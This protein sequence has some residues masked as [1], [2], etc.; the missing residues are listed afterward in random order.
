MIKGIIVFLS[1]WA[2]IFFGIDLF[3]KFTKQ[4]KIEYMKLL[5][6][7]LSVAIITSSLLTLMVILF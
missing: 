3:R 7:S 5:M 1:L 4:E 2:I 6:Y